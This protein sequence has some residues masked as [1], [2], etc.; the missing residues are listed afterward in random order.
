MLLYRITYRMKATPVDEDS[1]VAL[2]PI[3]LYTGSQ[4][5]AG[6]ARRLIRQKNGYVPNSVE[7]I[8]VNF[9]TKKD[10]I[11]DFLNSNRLQQAKYH[12]HE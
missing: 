5:D 9:P 8:K 6:A 3:E 1:D 11:I 7:T 4:S 12:I 2:N 10:G